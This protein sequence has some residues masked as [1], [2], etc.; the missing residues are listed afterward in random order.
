MWERQQLVL[1]G[2]CALL[3]AASREHPP[4]LCDYSHSNELSVKYEKTQIKT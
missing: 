3:G 2:N 4:V 1:Q